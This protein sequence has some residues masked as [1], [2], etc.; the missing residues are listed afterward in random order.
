MLKLSQAR[1]EQILTVRATCTW[2]NC[3][4]KSFDTGKVCSDYNVLRSYV[5]ICKYGF[6]FISHSVVWEYNYLWMFVFAE[7][8][9]W[10]NVTGL[11]WISATHDV[12]LMT[13]RHSAFYHRQERDLG[14]KHSATPFKRPHHCVVKHLTLAKLPAMKMYWMF[15]NL[16]LDN[17]VQTCWIM[18]ETTLSNIF[19]A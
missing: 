18:S 1:Q 6:S 4:K 16:G 2:T 17:R 7:I 8:C 12:L 19:L 11:L 13:K 5:R 10:F 14:D 3:V 9:K 15:F